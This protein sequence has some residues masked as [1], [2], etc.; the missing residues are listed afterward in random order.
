MPPQNTDYATD[1]DQI[2]TAQSRPIANWLKD[3]G[4][5]FADEI[6]RP[7]WGTIL[8]HLRSLGKW[9]AAKVWMESQADQMLRVWGVSKRKR[10]CKEITRRFV[11][12]KMDKTTVKEVTRATVAN[13]LA[14][15]D[16]I[17]AH[18]LWVF[19][20]PGLM[21]AEDDPMRQANASQYEK[22]HEAP[23]HGATNLYKQCRS[24]DKYAQKMFD[25]VNKILLEH[26]K[27]KKETTVSEQDKQEHDRILDMRAELAKYKE[28]AG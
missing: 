28:K 26:R 8:S 18:L 20:H 7:H 11:R 22:E 17:P 21:G 3:Q 27:K 12:A 15:L 16:L 23:N 25:E 2:L 19:L 5:E 9:E 13:D 6:N 10:V 4:L 1:A 14:E 24:D